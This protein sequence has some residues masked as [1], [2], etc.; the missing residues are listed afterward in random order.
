MRLVNTVKP[1]RSRRPKGTGRDP[2]IGIRCPAE[3]LARV[4]KWAENNKI[5]RS[6]SFRQFAEL[7]LA[8]HVTQ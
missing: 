1:K 6:E 3:L 4:D 8:K 7:A 5:T 2:F